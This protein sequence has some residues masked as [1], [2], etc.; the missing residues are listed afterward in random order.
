MSSSSSSFLVA[1]NF[2]LIFAVESRLLQRMLNFVKL[3]AKFCSNSPVCLKMLNCAKFP[4]LLG[5]TGMPH[6][7]L[8]E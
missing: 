8:F 1:V 3:G 2:V 4:G 7:W 5:M 6:I